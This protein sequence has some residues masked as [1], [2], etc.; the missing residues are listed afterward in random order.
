MVRRV[1][2]RRL[3]LVLVIL[4]VVGSP[5]RT[6]AAEKPLE[7]YVGNVATAYPTVGALL[8]YRD[9]SRTELSGLCSGVLVGCSTFVTAA[10]CICTDIAGAGTC[11]KP[12]RRCEHSLEVFLQH[13]GLFTV[14]NVAVDPDFA[15]GTRGDVA[16]ITLDKPV[17]GIAPSR[18]NLGQRVAPGTHGTVVGFGRTSAET[19]SAHD[20]GLKRFRSIATEDC[21]PCMPEDRLL[22]WTS[23][24]ER[25]GACEGDSGGPLLINAGGELVVAGLSAGGESETCAIPDTLFLTDM[26]VERD[27]LTR[28]TNETNRAAGCGSVTLGASPTLTT[29]VQGILTK[30]NPEARWSFAVPPGAYALRVALN[31][32][33]SASTIREEDNDFDLY[34]RRSDKPT[35]KRYDCR[36]RRRI[37]FA[38]CELGG[39]TEGMWHVLA[40][41]KSGAGQ[42][43]LTV[44][45]L[46]SD[47][48]SEGRC[49]PNG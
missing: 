36:D 34:V 5:S 38:A 14:R 22:C 48:A 27:W 28:V 43:Q 46:M 29:T 1:H 49:R 21:P 12:D 44:T 10:H 17:T 35:A 25:P 20:A 33:R 6:R 23:A 13:A 18:I 2:F 16:V 9:D 40:T 42:F 47:V 4:F 3:S 41:N 19:S 31:G 8:Y 39:P 24:R 11:A 15:F 32:Q 30:E 37:P 7:L 45:V 26:W